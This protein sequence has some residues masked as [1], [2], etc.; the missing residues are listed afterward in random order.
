MSGLLERIVR[1]RRASASSRLG[2]PSRN[3]AAYS[4]GAA[5]NGDLA[6]EE[7]VRLQTLVWTPEPGGAVASDDAAARAGDEA[8]VEDEAAQAAKSS[9]AT[10]EQP[11]VAQPEA[12]TAE[13]QPAPLPEPEPESELP[14]PRQVEPRPRVVAPDFRERGRMRRRA[15]YLRQLREIQLRDLG[16]FLLELHRFG[17]ERPDIVD[18]KLSGAAQTDAELRALEQA[19]GDNQRLREIREAGIGGAC[20]HCGAVHGSSDHFCSTCGRLLSTRAG[21]AESDGDPHDRRR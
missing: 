5:L 10:A 21:S 17:R 14:A 20:H 11:E 15:R 9:E 13:Q 1:R 12:E 7:E 2:P 6:R 19:L 4:N 8:V 18:A 3:G 16:G